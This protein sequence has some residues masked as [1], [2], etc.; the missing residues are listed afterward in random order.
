MRRSTSRGSRLQQRCEECPVGRSEPD[1]LA[2]QVPFED[3]DL[4]PEGQD[5]RVFGLVGHGQR[6][7]QRERVGHAEVRQSKQHSQASSPSHRRRSDA[8]WNVDRWKILVWA[9]KWP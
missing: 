6:P 8:C 2:V 3:C 4:V 1:L 5:F 9:S 7:E